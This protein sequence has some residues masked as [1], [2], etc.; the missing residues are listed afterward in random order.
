MDKL[1]QTAEILLDAH[2]EIWMLF[3][4]SGSDGNKKQPKVVKDM[5]KEIREFV[6]AYHP[7]I[8]ADLDAAG[9]VPE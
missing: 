6:R 9:P 8:L 2:A 1:Q 5:L 3:E 4:E 7:D